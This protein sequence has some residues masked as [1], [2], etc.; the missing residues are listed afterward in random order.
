MEVQGEL[1]H[2][3]LLL[4]HFEQRDI[5]LIRPAIVAEVG[6]MKWDVEAELADHGQ[7]VRAIL[8]EG[9]GT[10]AT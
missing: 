10:E 6:S 4:H 3:D 9:S 5:V 2:V 8:E 1:S 7:R